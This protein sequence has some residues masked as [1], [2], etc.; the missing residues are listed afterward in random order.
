VIDKSQY[1]LCSITS[2]K[3][4]FA[5]FRRRD[6]DKIFPTEKIQVSL[7]EMKK[8]YAQ[9]HFLNI[10]TKYVDVF[11]N[12][13]VANDITDNTRSITSTLFLFAFKTPQGSRREAVSRSDEAILLWYLPL[14]RIFY[15]THRRPSEK[16][17]SVW[18]DAL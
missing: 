3:L 1:R 5:F 14:Y 9:K 6:N 8:C 11:L 12:I 13:S 16:M 2:W 7:V 15:F 18:W 10:T 4:L 17:L